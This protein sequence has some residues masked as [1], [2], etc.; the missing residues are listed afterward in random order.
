[1]P[2][3]KIPNDILNCDLIHT[4]E[5]TSH[6]GHCFGSDGGTE[7]VPEGRG[8]EFR[9][10]KLSID[11]ESL[12]EDAYYLRCQYCLKYSYVETYAERQKRESI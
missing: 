3:I 8:G 10:W 9:V 2:I 4:G 6:A 11:K 1:M 5:C 7:K 12:L